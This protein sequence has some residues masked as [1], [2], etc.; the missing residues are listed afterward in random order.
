M[1][2]SEED[3]GR[4][5]DDKGEDRGGENSEEDGGENSEEDS[6]WIVRR[7]MGG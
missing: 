2:D 7:I 5:G 4:I 3:R 1:G 6:G